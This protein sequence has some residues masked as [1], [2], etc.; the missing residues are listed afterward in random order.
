[1]ES[2]DCPINEKTPKSESERNQF[3]R[4]LRL[5]ARS[6]AQ[7]L[8]AAAELHEQPTSS[9]HT[10]SSKTAGSEGANRRGF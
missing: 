8:R 9:R 7:R 1:M 5:L 2:E 10:C 6:I 3:N 4:L